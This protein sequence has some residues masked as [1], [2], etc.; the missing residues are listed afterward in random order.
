MS[1]K[2]FFSS[3]NIPCVLREN[4]DNCSTPPTTPLDELALKRHRFFADLIDAAN[5]AIEHRV[6]FDPLGPIVNEVSTIE[7]GVSD[8]HSNSKLI[9][10]LLHVEYVNPFDGTCY[11]FFILEINFLSIFFSCYL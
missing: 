3:P 10:M 5:A 4:S 9:K 6:R 8:G 2:I 7:T 1:Y 11:D